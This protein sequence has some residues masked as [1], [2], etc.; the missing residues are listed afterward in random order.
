VKNIKTILLK[1]KEFD[2]QFSSLRKK[3]R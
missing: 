3:R 2:E 1:F